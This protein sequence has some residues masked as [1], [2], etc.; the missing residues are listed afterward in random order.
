MNLKPTEAKRARV[1]DLALAAATMD[2]L[3][4]FFLEISSL[5]ISILQL[6]NVDRT[7]NAT[8][9]EVCL[10]NNARPG[11]DRPV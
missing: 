1:G 8:P 7:G 10:E 4:N 9:A 6:N 3:P 2:V 5:L 11:W